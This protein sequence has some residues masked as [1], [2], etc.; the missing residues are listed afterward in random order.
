MPRKLRI[1]CPSPPLPPSPSS[2][3]RRRPRRRWAYSPQRAEAD[4][5]AQLSLIFGIIGL[6]FAG[7]IFGPLAISQAG[8]AERMHK[9]AT[10]GKV[11]G[12]ISL[13]WGILVLI[14]IILW[15]V[16]VAAAVSSI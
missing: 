16:V 4:K 8:K 14:G 1:T 13:I 3:R 11:L 5:A 9:P 6:F 10:A 12:W 7:I 2:N 15:F